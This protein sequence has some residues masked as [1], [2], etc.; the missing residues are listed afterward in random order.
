MQI[1]HVIFLIVNVSELKLSLVS[2]H[3]QHLSKHTFA[4][5]SV[6]NKHGN[7]ARFYFENEDR[8]LLER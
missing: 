6:V 8:N 1:L 4:S 7:G 3:P 2:V 5:G